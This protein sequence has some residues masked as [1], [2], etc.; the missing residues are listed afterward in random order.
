MP[1][2]AVDF[3]ADIE[4]LHDYS[5]SEQEDHPRSE[6]KAENNESEAAMGNVQCLFTIG[7]KKRNKPVIVSRGT[8]VEK[9]FQPR[10]SSIRQE[11]ISCVGGYNPLTNDVTSQVLQS[12]LH[13][14]SASSITNGQKEEV[15]MGRVP[16]N[17]PSKLPPDLKDNVRLKNKREKLLQKLKIDTED[18]EPDSLS[19]T[20]S[21]IKLK[22]EFQEHIRQF[23]NQETTEKQSLAETDT[24]KDRSNTNNKTN[25]T[26]VL[27][28]ANDDIDDLEIKKNR[29]KKTNPDFLNSFKMS[30]RGDSD[31]FILGQSS[32][33]SD[34]NIYTNE[35]KPFYQNMLDSNASNTKGPSIYNNREHRNYRRKSY[36]SEIKGNYESKNN[37]SCSNCNQKIASSGEDYPRSKMNMTL[38]LTNLPPR[39]PRAFQGHGSNV[40]RQQV[41]TP[42]NQ[43][44]F[45]NIVEMN[46]SP[47]EE[48]IE[49]N[50]TMQGDYNFD[51]PPINPS[52]SPCLQKFPP[53]EY[54]DYQNSTPWTRS[55]SKSETRGM[56]PKGFYYPSRIPQPVTHKFYVSESDGIGDI[57]A[58][59]TDRRIKA[60][61][62]RHRCDIAIY[63]PIVRGG[64]MKYIVMLTAPSASEM[65]KCVRSLDTTLKWNLSSQLK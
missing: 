21:D 35:N 62:D 33:D 56:S 64:Y 43:S 13:S 11:N 57:L 54:L 46:Q 20:L 7:D 6:I 50:I 29:I 17:F 37:L 24:S 34:K 9:N 61:C 38:P 5:E 8:Q 1:R 22:C 45:A 52:R 14:S 32:E 40:K 23:Y 27:V 28:V 2:Y 10:F 12:T 53:G 16:S 4:E 49:H 60:V 25:V 39:A 48:V 51:S 42:R 36:S 47:I 18:D 31:P 58:D 41:V 15:I 3:I 65:K 44:N 30:E 26:D 59:T 55:R 63:S 19:D